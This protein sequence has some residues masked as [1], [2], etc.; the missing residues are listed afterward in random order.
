[1]EQGAYRQMKTI[2]THPFQASVLPP[3]Q[4]GAY[5][6]RP[7]IGGCLL[8]LV[9]CLHGKRHVPGRCLVRRGGKATLISTTDG[10]DKWLAQLVTSPWALCFWFPM[11]QQEK[12]NELVQP[13]R[14]SASPLRRLRRREV[15]FSSTIERCCTRTATTKCKTEVRIWNGGTNRIRELNVYWQPAGHSTIN[16]KLGARCVKRRRLHDICL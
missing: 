4:T 8:C 13:V 5:V 10:Q 12:I 9:C 14:Q 6:P 7:T 1:M 2:N 16:K 15:P 11:G 3:I